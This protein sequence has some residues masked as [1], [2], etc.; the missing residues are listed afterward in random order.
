[1]SEVTDQGLLLVPHAADGGDAKKQW[2]GIVFGHGLCG[3]A[4]G[5]TRQ[6]SKDFVP[7]ALSLSPTNNKKI[8]AWRIF[9]GL[10]QSMHSVGK[11]RYCVDSSVMAGNIK[12]NLHY[13]ASRTDVNPDALVSG[14]SQYGGWCFD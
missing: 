7:G 3:P 9:A 2:P 13:L 5:Y 4:R 10:I 11:F 6:H 12:K 14:R 8:V 1:M